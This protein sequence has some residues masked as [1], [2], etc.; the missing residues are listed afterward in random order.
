MSLSEQFTV[1]APT[2]ASPRPAPSS[3]S[4]TG[5]IVG[6]VVG[7]VVVLCI[8]GAII[9]FILRKRR[10]QRQAEGEMG[11]AA[12]VPMMKGEKGHG[13][14]GSAQYGGQSRM[15]SHK[16]FGTHANSWKQ[17]HP[18]TL[19]Q[20]RILTSILHPQK[21]IAHIISTPKTLSIRKSY[22]PR[23]PL[24]TDIPN[25]QP[26]SQAVR[27]L[28]GTP[29][30]LFKPREAHRNSNHRRLPLGLCNQS[31]QMIWRNAQV[32]LKGWV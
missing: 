27:I 11:A 28:N 14:R 17:R 31:S 18:H 3:K 4:N 16:R 32:L 13:S 1:Y 29:N 12:M 25:F 26:M 2:S 9:F 5:A 30:F 19:L 23:R 15:L 20:S 7:G 24:R 21:F 22:Q 10:N 6:G 8:V